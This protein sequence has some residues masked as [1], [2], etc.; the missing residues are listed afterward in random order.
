MTID[1]PGPV[2]HRGFY[3]LWCPARRAA[4]LVLAIA[5]ALALWRLPSGYYLLVPGETRLSRNLVAVTG[6]DGPGRGRLLLVTVAARPA[7][8]GLYILG[9][10]LPGAELVSEADL[11][12]P[13]LSYEEFQKQNQRMMA[14]S[15]VAAKKAALL[16]AGRRGFN[17]ASA[18]SVQGGGI[19]GPSA[20]LPIAL[21]V[22]DQL[23]P[24]D[25]TGGRIIAATGV[26]DPDGRVGR[27]GGMAQKVLAAER[28][29]ATLML[30]PKGDEPAARRLAHRL[31]VV[32]VE[33]L[34]AALDY[35][36]ESP[37]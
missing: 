22:I 6:S 16:E 1:S 29:G 31:R 11:T 5:L 15:L 2:R 17:P 33:S 19:A 9:R 4:R 30:V 14:E 34:G 26:L 24:G 28:A 37:R 23:T 32:G 8:F 36:G 35:L 13:G 12:G 3:S 18:V 21:E 27:V 10:F 25:L 7:G 20:G